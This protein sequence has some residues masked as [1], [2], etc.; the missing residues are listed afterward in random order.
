MTNLIG[1]K[2]ELEQFKASIFL[3][4]NKE[5]RE[6]L[7]DEFFSTI[8]KG[9]NKNINQIIQIVEND[10]VR[11]EKFHKLE[12]QARKIHEF[13]QKLLAR[14]KKLLDERAELL[15][16]YENSLKERE[17]RLNTLLKKIKGE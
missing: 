4:K 5:Q 15:D 10:I 13:E 6:F 1:L 9:L 12:E 17:Y 14:E 16:K 8:I 3:A 2:N 7:T 11:Q